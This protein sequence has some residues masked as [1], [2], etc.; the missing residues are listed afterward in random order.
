MAVTAGSRGVSDDAVIDLTDDR[1]QSYSFFTCSRAAI[2]LQITSNSF[3]HSSA[4]GQLSTFTYHPPLITI[5]H[6]F[7]TMAQR[8]AG[9]TAHMVTRGARISTP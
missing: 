8:A 6:E 7:G 1:R 2:M 9:S 3:G 4:S 5:P